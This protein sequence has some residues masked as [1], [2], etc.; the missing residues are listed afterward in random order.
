MAKYLINDTT[1]QSIADAIR[2]KKGTS[3]SITVSDFANQISSIEGGGGGGTTTECTRKH[4][5]ELEAPPRDEAVEGEVYRVKSKALL[6]VG[7]FTDD[8]FIPDYFDFIADVFGEPLPDGLYIYV[9]TATD[10]PTG[11]N[12]PSAIKAH[13]AGFAYVEDEDMLYGCTSESGQWERISEETDSDLSY[14]GSVNSG[15]LPTEPGVYAVLG[16]KNAEFYEVVPES[17]KLVCRMGLGVTEVSNIVPLELKIVPTKPTEDIVT[18]SESFYCFYYIEDEDNLFIHDGV[19]WVGAGESTEFSGSTFGGFIDSEAQ[20]TDENALYILGNPRGIVRHVHPDGTIYITESDTYDVSDYAVVNVNIPDTAVYGIRKIVLSNL[21]DSI[22]VPINFTTTY[23]G[24]TVKCIGMYVEYDWFDACYRLHYNREDGG[25]IQ[26]YDGMGGWLPSPESLWVDFG[27]EPQFVPGSF[28]DFIS[29][30]IPVFDI[31]KLEDYEFVVNGVG[32]QAKPAMNWHE[33]ALD[34]KH[35]TEGFYA[36]YSYVT[37][38]GQQLYCNGTSVNWLDLII[39][40]AIYTSRVQIAFT[41]DG[42]HYYAEQ[43][44][45]WAD[46]VNDAEYPIGDIYIN[47]DSGVGYMCVRNIGPIYHNGTKVV[48]GDA[49]ISGAAYTTDNTIAF[50]IDSISYKADKGMTWSEWIASGYNTGSRYMDKEG[51]VFDTQ[52]GCYVCLP[53]GNHVA[54]AAEITDGAEYILPV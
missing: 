6:S 20:V 52:A 28:G 22:T 49:I 26:V 50:T 37:K 38:D 54:A 2:A 35:Q 17:S 16:Y 48:A 18:S 29:Q 5:I 42:V 9:K 4:V 19:N 41:V 39:N 47:A 13:E 1:L 7:V 8:K 11:D 32:Y 36:D 3:G 45:T 51:E 33:F 46:W 40:G 25:S 21:P 43:D 44:M 15:E 27:P 23:E 24:E 12:L 34:S 10:L 14:M 30:A 53:N 31:V